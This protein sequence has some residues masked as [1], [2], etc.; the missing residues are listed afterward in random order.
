MTAT[1]CSGTTDIDLSAAAMCCSGLIPP[2]LMRLA[3]SAAARAASADALGAMSD[4]SLASMPARGRPTALC[5]TSA[6]DLRRTGLK[7]DSAH[8]TVTPRPPIT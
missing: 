6:A 1:E 2:S 3:F 7:A 4:A 5:V 8:Q